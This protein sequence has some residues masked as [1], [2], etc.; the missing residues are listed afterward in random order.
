MKTSEMSNRQ[1]KAFYN[2][3]YAA[4]WMLGGLENTLYDEPENSKEYQETK[5]LLENHDELVKKLYEL[6]TT[7]MFSEGFCNC[8]KGVT[9]KELRD[10]NFC[11]KQWLLERCN[12][13]IIKEGY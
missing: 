5:A 7:E 8:N 11:G 6:A 9:T 1:K 2:I 3:K 10:I 4:Y 12:K 13:R